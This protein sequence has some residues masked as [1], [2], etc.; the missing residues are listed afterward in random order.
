MTFKHATHKFTH[1]TLTQRLMLLA[2]L[3]ALG[4]VGWN[5]LGLSAAV[6]AYSNTLLNSAVSP[7]QDPGLTDAQRQKLAELTAAAQAG[8]PFSLEERFVLDRFTR[9]ESVNALEADTVISRV[10]LASYVTRQGTSRRMNQLLI[11]YR[12][13][14]ASRGRTILDEATGG[15]TDSTA[16]PNISTAPL[17]VSFTEGFDNIATLSGAG[18]AQINN[19]SPV[20][21]I[22]WFQGNAAVF[23]SHM[24]AVTSYIGTNFNNTT[25]ANTISN[26][27]IT[28]QIALNNGDQ[29]T[30]ESA[31]RA[32]GRYADGGGL[33]WRWQG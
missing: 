24:G 29:F 31:V 6:L 5:L 26:W 4:V 2:L 13:L 25:G 28:P 11:A 16:A 30:F 10:L 33:R 15:R 27:L 12:Q 9:G 23:P 14:V 3:G 7:A 18:W 1:R 22:G 19:S 17:G 20:G 8:K 32:A 21:T